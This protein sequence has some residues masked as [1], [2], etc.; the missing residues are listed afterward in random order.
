MGKGK[1]SEGFKEENKKLSMEREGMVFMGK[2]NVS[3]FVEERN[4]EKKD[5]YGVEGSSFRKRR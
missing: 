1:V 2:M 4:R 3:E 5:Y